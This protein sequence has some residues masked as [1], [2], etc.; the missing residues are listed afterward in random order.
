MRPITL[1][2]LSLLVSTP[3]R[4]ERSAT[5]AALEGDA[6]AKEGITEAAILAYQEALELDPGMAYPAHQIGILMYQQGDA[7]GAVKWLEKAT[8]IEPSNAAFWQNLSLARYKAGNRTGA[9]AASRKALEQKP[10]D[11][12]RLEWLGSLLLEE[13]NF[14]EAHAVL[15][16]AAQSG[17]TGAE[18]NTLLGSAA[19][20]SGRKEE[21][22]QAWKQAMAQAPNADLAYNYAIAASDTGH[23]DDAIAA[24]DLVLAKK[25]DDLDALGFKAQLY[26]KNNQYARAEE[27][28][29][30]MLAVGGLTGEARRTTLQEYGD[31]LFSQ[32]GR[33]ADAAGVY[34][35]IT[36]LTPEDGPAWLDY[37]RALYFG[38]RETEAE[39]AFEKAVALGVNDADALTMLGQAALESKDYPKARQR[40]EAATAA[41][42]MRGD[43]WFL[44]GRCRA[45]QQ[46]WPGAAEAFGKAVGINGQDHESLFNLGL[47]QNQAGDSA[48]AKITL[49]RYLAEAPDTPDNQA[50]RSQ[51]KSLLG[52]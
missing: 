46:E 45:A 38:K 1:L 18:F 17:R 22:Y 19:F 49:E 40:L 2:A 52:R 4:A 35:Q 41:N 9:I 32:T 34:Q 25:P 12:D 28:Y 26:R 6:L 24:L 50:A 11:S 30:A 3:A 27:A 42:P 13:E 29:K 48:G 51:A 20:Q 39:A 5:E 15:K 14:E 33:E 7:A 16:K 43:A 21:A 8:E 23:T 44:L 37:G 47:A 36:K 31:W 10:G